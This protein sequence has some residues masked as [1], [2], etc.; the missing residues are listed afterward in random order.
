MA[1]VMDLV[2]DFH[3][4]FHHQPVQN[5]FTPLHSTKDTDVLFPN[6]SS[7]RLSRHL[8]ALCSSQ[9]HKAQGV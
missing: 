7:S 1:P 5:N 6:S 9:F 4:N 8:I 3:G 2:T